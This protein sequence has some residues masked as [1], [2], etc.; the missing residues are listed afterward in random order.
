MPNAAAACTFVVVAT[1]W[2]AM[3]V[4][5]SATNQRLRGVRVGHRLLRR[6]GLAG[7]DEQRLV[8]LHPPQHRR[9]IVAVDVGDEVQ[10]QRR[11]RERVE[12]A[13]RHL[14]PEIGAADA[15]VDDMT[16]AARRRVAHA[17]G[18][19]EHALEHVV[20]LVAERA[21]S[22][23]RAQR[24]VQHGTAF[25][26]VDR[27]PAQHRIAL[28]LDAAV[29]CER[30]QPLQRGRIEQ[31]LRQVGDD[32]GR[33][34]AQRLE[35]RRVAGERVAQVEVAAVRV[36]MAAQR[37]PRGRAV[38]T[39]GVH[40]ISIDL[41]EQVAVRR[42]VARTAAAA[43]RRSRAHRRRWC[44]PAR[45]VAPRLPSCSGRARVRPAGSSAPSS[46]RPNEPSMI[47]PSRS[48]R[49]AALSIASAIAGPASSQPGL[50][51]ARAR[52]PDSARAS[53]HAPASSPASR[54]ARLE[55]PQRGDARAAA[56]RRLAAPASAERQRAD[57]AGIAVAAPPYRWL[58]ITSPPPTKV[59]MNTYRKLRMLRPWPT[60]S[61][62][63]QAAVV[64]LTNST[65]S[66]VS[67]SM[68]ARMSISFHFDGQLRRDAEQR[69][70]SRRATAARRRRCRA[71][72]RAAPAS[73]SC[74]AAAAAR[75]SRRTAC[76]GRG[77][78]SRATA[79]SRTCADEVHQQH[80]QAAAADLDADRERAVGV[81]RHRHR[82]LADLAAHRRVLEHQAVGLEPGDDD[83]HRLRASA[84]SAARRRPS[85]SGPCSR[86]ACS[87][88]RSLNWRMPTWF[89][90]RG[91]SR[92]SATRRGVRRAQSSACTV[93]QCARHSAGMRSG[94]IAPVM[95]ATVS[96]MLILCGLTHGGAL[97]QPL[98]VDA[99]GDLEHVRHV[100]A[101]QNHRQ[102]LVAHAPDQLEHHVRLPSR[103]A[104]RSARP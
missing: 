88:M 97:A 22:A 53:A 46:S 20:Y 1:K 89:E 72:A 43:R 73:A 11:V 49:Q 71:A 7:D 10:R 77:R 8:R 33:V 99:V 41:Q 100:V 92:A 83:L 82:R 29:G 62:A 87:T 50:R 3:S 95:T 52:A 56:R 42:E 75:R 39:E 58:S 47:T 30:E 19:V 31:V 60:T 86:I 69:R 34:D 98:D 59:S 35:S 27:L 25:G 2:R 4:P 79:R 93:A 81:Q 26:A 74:A 104:R 80:V 15:D 6:E 45:A 32:L 18:E 102:A 63:T 103:R 38:A 16:D 84:A 51:R 48:S 12:R 61:S 65:G 96:L 68:R 40:H 13:H 66:C 5:P 55:V 94:G 91:R 23:W 37:G 78:R 76:R 24:G 67:A 70:A 85:G 14:R 21:Q 57:R 90:P 64:S 44:R 36:E 17:L 9:E 101:D 54:V 28:R